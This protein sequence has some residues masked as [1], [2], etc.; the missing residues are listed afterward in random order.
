[1]EEKVA[2]GGVKLVDRMESA[3]E[4]AGRIREECHFQI[5]FSQSRNQGITAVINHWPKS[6][7]QEDEE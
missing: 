5:P 3:E 7:T 2:M 4:I 6:S 1:M